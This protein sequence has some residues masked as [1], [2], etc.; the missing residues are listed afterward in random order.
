VIDGTQY[1][2]M[3]YVEGRSL[4]QRLAGGQ[5]QDPRW[6]AELVRRVAVALEAVHER[7]IV[8]RDLKPANIM[9][10]SSDQ[11]CVVDFGLARREQ[12]ATITRAGTVV[13][14]PAY[15]SPEQVEGHPITRA[16]DVYSLGVI[17]YQLLTGKVPFT[18]ENLV[19]VTYKIVNG[20]LT[21]PSQHR[22]DSDPALE[23]I[24]LW[25]MTRP[26][27]DRC[28][29][30]AAF[31]AALGDYLGGPAPAGRR[32]WRQ[33]VSRRPR[34]KRRNRLAAALSGRW[35]QVFFLLVVAVGLGAGTLGIFWI[36]EAGRPPD[37]EL[38]LSG[39]TPGSFD[40]PPVRPWPVEKEPATREG[41][42]PA[43][44]AISPDGDNKVI[45][46][47]SDAALLAALDQLPGPDP[48]QAKQRLEEAARRVDRLAPQASVKLVKAE[49]LP[50]TLRP[51]ADYI[52]AVD[53]A[54]EGNPGA[55]AQMARLSLASADALKQLPQKEE[56]YR[57]YLEALKTVTIHSKDSG[58]GGQPRDAA[59]VAAIL[60]PITVLGGEL[61]PKGDRAFK[62]QFAQLCA[63]EADLI[64]RHGWAGVPFLKEALPR[65]VFQLYDQAVKNDPTWAEY[66]AWRGTA[67]IDLPATDRD[68]D[69]EL[70]RAD[71]KLAAEWKGDSARTWLLSSYAYH[72]QSRQ[73]LRLEKRVEFLEKAVND[74]TRALNLPQYKGDN[75][76]QVL[77]TYRS[78]AYLEL[79]SA[80]LNSKKRAECLE[81]AR[82]DAEDAK[83]ADP[84]QPEQAAQALGHALEDIGWLVETDSEKKQVRY[85]QAVEAYGQA[86][87]SQPNYPAFWMDR[88]RVR[89]RWVKDARGDANELLPKARKDLTAA[90]EK[91]TTPLEKAKAR[92]E[93]ARVALLEDRPDEAAKELGE[94]ANL[95]DPRSKDLVVYAFGWAESVKHEAPKDKAAPLL[96]RAVR[97]RMGRVSTDTA[98]WRAAQAQ[99][100][101]WSH[102]VE[103][104]PELALKEY[105]RAMPRDL[106]RATPDDLPILL[107]RGRLQLD[108]GRALKVVPQEVCQAARRAV[109]L[110]EADPG[111][112][113]DL[114]H[115]YGFLGAAWYEKSREE[116]EA[117]KAPQGGG[118]EALRE[119]LRPLGEATGESVEAFQKA[120]AVP[121]PVKGP[122]V[123]WRYRLACGLDTQAVILK[124]LKEKQAEMGEKVRA[125]RR[126]L[127]EAREMLK[128]A[129]IAPAEAKGLAEKIDEELAKLARTFGEG[130][131]K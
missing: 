68:C 53:L 88:A 44:V 42:A 95:I 8:H 56:A 112:E 100:L 93:V 40:P 23:E 5:P 86:I 36:K 87:A 4:A 24:C 9:L 12:D 74:Y 119:A 43:P 33:P 59:L 98:E 83:K 105:D 39:S 126:S 115:A 61:A 25:A 84:L 27:K 69:L 58:G 67:R 89:V 114:A 47:W 130:T 92:D 104:H 76:R 54:R 73:Q 122:G 28:P 29:T 72:L 123:V 120:L 13:G 3:D 110:A 131:K 10:R 94:A 17:L 102:E 128:E 31:A 48:S 63:Q 6:S 97:E 118:T 16:T 82:Q 15:M 117:F 106:S 2:T 11:P 124:L 22:P 125:A 19:Q 38:A 26:V 99:A 51:Y 71:A 101:A 109:E 77:L 55:T 111:A 62:V 78:R 81:K 7:G 113:A 107:A 64:R 52:V 75:S 35:W 103:H 46:G 85:R 80:T 108:Q 129:Q 50:P 14:T 90:L 18:G 49:G 21:P 34:K 30:M 57:V 96:A 65:K 45:T 32:S 66:Y 41:T 116:F 79:G 127:E 20:E 1:I 70:I 60:E 121:L 91:A 37:S